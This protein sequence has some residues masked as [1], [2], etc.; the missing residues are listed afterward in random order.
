[1][2]LIKKKE[3]ISS[4]E[5]AAF[6]IAEP[7]EEIEVADIFRL[8]HVSYHLDATRIRR[9]NI[10]ECNSSFKQTD[11]FRPKGAEDTSP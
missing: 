6:C 3:L 9:D 2:A 4:L 7:A 1:M 10:V 5:H 11:T 8:G